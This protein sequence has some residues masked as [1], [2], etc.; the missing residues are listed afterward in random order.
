SFLLPGWILSRRL[1]SPLPIYTAFIGSAAILFLL[2]LFLD[3]ANLPVQVGTLGI[4]FALISAILL[5][6]YPKGVPLLP[7][8]PTVSLPRD[9]ELLWLIPPIFALTS[10]ALRAVL[11]PLS[12]FDNSFR[13]DYLARLLLAR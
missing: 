2:K 9:R 6:R 3:L 10:I 1:A 5:W 7:N 12:G 11:D 4:G 8:R 13:W